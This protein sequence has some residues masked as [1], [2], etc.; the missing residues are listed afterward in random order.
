M[1]EKIRDRFS[2]CNTTKVKS[3]GEADEVG[4]VVDHG[5]NLRNGLTLTKHAELHRNILSNYTTAQC[6]GVFIH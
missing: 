2:V 6:L 4:K 5:C 3:S 1:E